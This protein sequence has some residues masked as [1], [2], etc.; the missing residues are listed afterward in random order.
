MTAENDAPVFAAVLAGGS[1]SR[2]WPKSRAAVPKQ[3]LSFDG[4]GSLLQNTV[5]R[6]EQ[7]VVPGRILVITN[8]A[9]E[10]GVRE[11]LDW[12]GGDA[13][14]V[15]PAARNT[16]PAVALAAVRAVERGGRRDAVTLVVPSDHSIRGDAG[17]V[18]TMKAAIAAA[19]CGRLVTVG[20][21][22]S[23]A[24][25][26]Y[27]YILP[28]P[29]NCQLEGLPVMAVRRFVEKPDRRRAAAYLRG[30]RH[31]WNTGIF[32]WQAGV[33]LAAMDR[34]AQGAGQALGELIAAAG[35][36]D[37]EAELF[38][39]LPSLSIDHWVL[40]KEHGVVMIAA[41]F[42]WDDLGSWSSFARLHT[43]DSDGNVILGQAVTL[44]SRDC[45]IDCG[46][47]A[48]VAALGVKDLIIVDTGDVLLVCD[49]RRDQEVKAL[50]DILRAAG[51]E[52][53][54]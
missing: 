9:C 43:P 19:R 27:G 21:R 41:E 3:L 22:P 51:L 30:G 6:L 16:G 48:V 12:L 29:A 28:G 14:L 54:L 33:I 31:L 42:G 40:E 17:Y 26:G 39:A 34:H 49:R 15:E 24:E 8:E 20:V 37:R 7:L 23:R 38:Q 10:S 1:G 13:I 2:F 36:P 4:S 52:H 53:L 45:L 25:T 35:S 32:A 11:Q 18:S 5:R 47:K 46:A 50:R 44:G